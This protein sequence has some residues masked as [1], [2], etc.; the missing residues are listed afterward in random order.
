MRFLTT[1]AGRMLCPLYFKE[2]IMTCNCNLHRATNLTTGGL[3]TVTNSNNI[4]NFDCFNLV[5]C[6]SPNNIITSSP[7]PYAV[8]VNGADIPIVDIWGYP[9]TTDRLCPRKVYR[10]R[11]IMG[12]G[13]TT[14]IT[15]TNLCCTAVDALAASTTATTTETNNGE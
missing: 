12:T 1:W 3:L 2:M 15:L 8:T 10:G 14:H 6:L 11:Y 5:L 4:S 7:L 9:V 13:I